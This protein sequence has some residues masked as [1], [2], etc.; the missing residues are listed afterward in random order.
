[1]PAKAACEKVN[2]GIGKNERKALTGILRRT[3]AN[4]SEQE[5]RRAD[6]QDAPMDAMTF[7]AIGR[8]NQALHRI[9]KDRGM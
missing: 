2:A 8:S 4:L 6:S 9:L 1:M 3:A 5:D 7:C